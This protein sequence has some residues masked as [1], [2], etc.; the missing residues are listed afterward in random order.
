[1]LNHYL[2]LA[3]RNFSKKKSIFFINLF[4]LAVGLTTLLLITV[5][6]SSELEV[7]SAHEN[8]DRIYKVFTN[9]DNSTGIVTIPVTPARMAEAMREELPQIEM[10][11]GVSPF[12]DGV[13]FASETEKVS[14]DGYY[15]DQEFL[16]I[17]T[18]EF[19]AGSQVD[20]L[21]DLNSVVISES[22]AETLFGDA[23]KAIGE[24]LE[25]QVF[26]FS[27]EVEV[28]GVFKDVTDR[29]FIDHPQFLL[30]FDY[31]L[32]MLGDGAHWDNYNGQAIALL[33]PEV[34]VDEFN[35]SFA[36]F[37]KDKEAES[38]VT[39]FIQ[40]FEETYLNSLYEGGKVA[41][42]RISY[43]Y[44]FAAIAVFILF[45]ACINFMN[46]TTARAMSRVKEIGVKKT[47]GANRYGLF[48][49]FMTES[50]L[51]TFMALL[52][53]MVLIFALL[54]FFNQIT[55]KSLDISFGV[56][57]ISLLVFVWVFT[58]LV[59]GIYPSLYLSRFRPI[60]ILRSTMKGSFGELLARKGLVIFQFVISLL[61]IIG[62]T[63]ISRQINFIQNQNLG[64]N[65][66]QLLQIPA[67]DFNTSEL[68]TFL[69]QLRKVPGVENASSL[70]HVL[71]GLTSSTI[72]LRWDGKDEN[73]QV[74]FENITVN[75]G[76][77][78]TMDFELVAGRSFSPEYGEE[79]EKL[80]L[81]EEA[82]RVIGLEDPVGKILNLWG[83]DMEVIGVLKNF[84]FE[85]LKEG[86]KPAFL[87]YDDEFSTKIMVRISAQNQE[88]TLAAVD[89]L[90]QESKGVALDYSFLDEDFQSLYESEKRISSLAKYFGAIAIFLSC[91]GLFGLAAFTAEQRR[92][93]IGVRKVL[94]AS[95]SSIL[96]LVTKDFLQLILW[97]ILISIPLGWYFSSTW[98]DSYAY[99]TNL[100]WI[101]FASSSLLLVMIAVIT[102]GYQA[103][104]AAKTN[105]VNSLRSE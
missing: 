41:G 14:A 25:W 87:K 35:A 12:I 54:P 8:G 18:L 94:G 62:I 84:N 98:L 74:K 1:M 72:G 90:Y 38:N 58:S 100:S 68:N 77:I 80:I 79:R 29:Q 92:K 76:L 95:I 83:D 85:S 2:R 73:E 67:Y 91:L 65:Q 88:E 15:A 60:Q 16:E 53:A 102:V 6:V 32:S 44:I 30:T 40:A 17:F 75:L 36:S 42:G 55:A 104:Q 20:A 51:L 69:E 96:G 86:V 105:P 39:P 78:E 56:R 28:K 22:M 93:E 48:S 19:V 81:N 103:F 57:E 43:V 46:L 26:S 52:L 7:L 13:S 11:A 21:T 4:G 24:S 82:V 99:K 5:W 47:M 59:A 64:Y 50:F 31:F 61:L 71:T 10:A 9:H 45:I 23:Q 101:I 33:N 34:N 37:I 70:N 97:A 66:A 63:V 49:Q 89:D 27:N 3:I